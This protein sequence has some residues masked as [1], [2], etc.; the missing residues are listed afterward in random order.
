[1]E[2]RGREGVEKTEDRNRQE[3]RQL[4]KQ[5]GRLTAEIERKGIQSVGTVV[6]EMSRWQGKQTKTPFLILKPFS[7]SKP[8]SESH[9]RKQGIR[10][11]WVLGISTLPY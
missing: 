10:I 8:G 2:R 9:R 4:L 6:W 3:R 7:Q 11:E 1:M 5:E